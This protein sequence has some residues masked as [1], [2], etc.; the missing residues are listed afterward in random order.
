M[1]ETEVELEKR[2]S[3]IVPLLLISALVLVI[4]G[5]IGWFIF[6]AKRTLK[7]EE[8]TKLVAAVLNSQRQAAIRFRTG[9]VE[10]DAADKLGDPHYR[11]L[12]KA[13]ILKIGKGKDGITPVALTPAAEETLA[14][15]PELKKT[16]DKKGNVAYVVPLAQRKLVG[17]SK[18]T[19]AGPNVA[20]VE[21]TWEWVPNKFGD[22]FDT[23]GPYVKRFST[24]ERA[25]LIQKYGADFYH[26]GPT[27][28]VVTLVRS[29]EGWTVSR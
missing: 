4:A 16:Q 15:F 8:A 22:V 23:E 21:Y 7:P 24:Y 3:S 2:S 26:A 14:T 1:F 10:A 12:E 6:E 25:T 28:T 20:T 27:K 5:G 13:G 29:D 11:L 19:M 9:Q 18:V 17:V